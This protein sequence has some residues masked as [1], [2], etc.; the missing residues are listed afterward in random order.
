MRRR[1]LIVASLS[2]V[3]GCTAESYYAQGPRTPPRAP[4]TR[5]PSGSRST[6]DPV[7][8]RAQAIVRP[9]NEV[10]RTVRGP[11]DGF[12]VDDVPREELAAAEASLARAREEL[13][14]FSAAV[15]DP[16]TDYR[17]LPTLVAAHA[18]LL[19]ALAAAVDLHSSLAAVV[20]NRADD[21][22]AGLATAREA[23]ESLS[24]AATDLADA[25]DADPTVPA[26]LFLTVDRMRAF[27]T[28]LDAQSAA[29]ERLV[30]AASRGRAADARWR[31][32]V[33][34][35]DRRR[36][37]EARTAFRAARDVYRG[38]DASLDGGLDTEGAFADLA[39][40]AAC[41]AVA[42]VEAASTALE[43]VDAAAGGDRARADAT[44]DR[45]ETTRNRCL[46]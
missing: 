44:L 17:S 2:V 15:D 42:G 45:A 26:S 11:L 22:A 20:A 10:Y 33:V 3:A 30:D 13:A 16:P 46:D 34:A 4:E 40:T 12:E 25:A 6:L 32:G 8:A 27:A 1:R 24:T 23:V 37:A 9:L 19:D 31:E 5:A 35:F 28:G 38:V 36:Y 7:E 39:E 29:V 21:P 18:S 41:A 14:S 43:A